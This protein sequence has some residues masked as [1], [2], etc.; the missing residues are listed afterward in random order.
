[1]GIREALETEASFG[2][3]KILLRAIGEDCVEAEPPADGS[4]RARATEWI[5]HGVA[6]L[7]GHQEKR[8]EDAF[9]FLGGVSGLLSS[10]DESDVEGHS[11][12]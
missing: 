11:D 1:L 6:A 8:F 3:L 4:G 2:N 7:G 10:A 5:N 12:D 9:W